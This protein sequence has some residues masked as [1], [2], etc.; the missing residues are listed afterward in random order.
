VRLLPL[1][2]LTACT[3][4]LCV[5]DVDDLGAASAAPAASDID[6]SGA[7]SVTSYAWDG[8]LRLETTD[9]EGADGL[10]RGVDY[11]AI[12]ASA[13]AMDTL[14]DY[15]GALA[16]VDPGALADADERLAY[17]LNA[18]NAWTLYAVVGE[19]DADPDYDV[20]AGGFLLFATRFVEVD[21]VALTL[22]ELEG[23]VLRGAETIWPDDATEAAGNAWHEE[24]FGDGAPDAR[25]HMGLNCSSR[26]CP[27][28]SPGAFQGARVDEQLETLTA[29]FLDHAGKGAGPNGVSQLFTWYKAD[30]EADAGSVEAFIDAHRAG[31]VDGVDLDARLPYDWSLN[32]ATTAP[33]ATCSSA[34]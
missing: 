14:G 6:L 8:L 16:T 29:A 30:F 24:L 1:L 25:L 18:Y 5:T 17:W 34:W 20:E 3:D 21:G 15:V 31:G 4:L 2:G 27:N 11:D 10:D 22:N 12:L 26:S 13:E 7:G 32:R 9:E 23:G 28:L 19:L 33:G